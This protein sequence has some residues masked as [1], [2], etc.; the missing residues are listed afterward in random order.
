MIKGV[1]LIVRRMVRY[2]RRVRVW[3]VEWEELWVLVI[4]KEGVMIKEKDRVLSLLL[5]AV[6]FVI[7]VKV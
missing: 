5:A 3:E 7:K 1:W 6:V 2:V 4:R